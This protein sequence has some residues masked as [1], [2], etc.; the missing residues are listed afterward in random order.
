M[1]SRRTCLTTVAAV[2]AL[3][4]VIAA[5]GSA[6]ARRRHQPAMQGALHHLQQAKD[7]L[8]NATSD[9]GGHRQ[10]A[11]DLTNQAIAE[12]EKGIAYDAN[13]PGE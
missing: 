5:S 12:V 6:L 1:R 8:Q 2:A 3:A 10:R 11:L 13:H 7:G 4:S 9:K